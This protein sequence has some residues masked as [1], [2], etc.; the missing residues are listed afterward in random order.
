[1]YNRRCE[2]NMETHLFE[3]R[4]NAVHFLR[5][6]GF[7][8]WEP[9]PDYWLKK[10]NLSDLFGDIEEQSKGVVLV[11]IHPG[12]DVDSIVNRRQHQQERKRSDNMRS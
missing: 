10:D 5:A 11:V 2:V 4:T 12:S 3:S 6:N 7:E 1:M 8:F 9:Y